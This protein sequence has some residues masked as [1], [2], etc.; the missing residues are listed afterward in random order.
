MS[1]PWTI[2]DLSVIES[3][4]YLDLD[5]TLS[6][7]IFG[8]HLHAAELVA[9][10]C[11]P[12]RPPHPHLLTKALLKLGLAAVISHPPLYF[13]PSYRGPRS[14]LSGPHSLCVGQ[15][16]GLCSPKTFTPTPAHTYTK[17]LLPAGTNV[18]AEVNVLNGVD[19]V[20]LCPGHT[21]REGCSLKSA[22][23]GELTYLSGLSQ[24]STPRTSLSFFIWGSWRKQD[25][26]ELRC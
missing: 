4:Q 6:W 19:T 14:P 18:I 2:K 13:K 25:E 23:T 20:S 5:P 9:Q 11:T 26:L 16:V 7:V 22:L 17:Q 12:P 21:L 10:H 8:L 15:S 24:C 3:T 1:P